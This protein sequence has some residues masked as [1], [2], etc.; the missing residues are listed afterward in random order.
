MMLFIVDMG[1]VLAQSFDI[2]PEAARRLAIPLDVMRALVATDMPALLCGSISA[3][4]YWQ[5]FAVASGVA[6]PEDYWSTLFAPVIDA[7]VEGILDGL[8]AHGRVVCGTNTIHSHYDY[9]AAAGAYR[10]FDRV[11]ASQRMGICK[12]DPDFWRAILA[13]EETDPHEALFI[14]DMEENIRAAANLGL[15]AHQFCGAPSLRQALDDV[16]RAA[17]TRA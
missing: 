5:R 11:Y 9:L 3:D 6:V 2:V 17:G 4:E 8:R 16:L 15:A 1:G 7:E 12:P 10:C 14:D 13:T